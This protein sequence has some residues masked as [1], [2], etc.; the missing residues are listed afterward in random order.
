M[1]RD[2]FKSIWEEAKGRYTEL[3]GKDLKDIPMARTSEDLLKNIDSQNNQYK[4][5]RETKVVPVLD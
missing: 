1:P 2:D 5:F 4:G 3:S